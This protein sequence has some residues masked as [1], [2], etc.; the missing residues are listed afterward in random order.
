[1]KAN[2]GR[3]AR[4]RQPGSPWRALAGAALLALA[5]CAAPNARLLDYRAATARAIATSSYQD[6]Y[7]RGNTLAAMD[8]VTVAS[9][10]NEPRIVAQSVG[11]IEENAGAERGA[12]AGAVSLATW[13]GARRYIGETFE[14]AWASVA[15]GAA[16]WQLGQHDNA[17]ALWRNAAQIDGESDEGYREDYG[18]ANFLLAKW[19]STRRNEPDNA[20]IYRDRLLR[21]APQAQPIATDAALAGD[22]VVLLLENGFGPRK[23][24]EGPQG[25]IL[26]YSEVTRE[27][28]FA[29][30]RAN[31]RAVGNDS[32][33]LVDMRLQA[34]KSLRP[35]TKE[36]WQA[37]RG[38][39]VAT[40]VGYGV[41]ELT[42]DPALGVLAALTT[43]A[44]PADQ[45]QWLAVPGEVH[46]ISARLEPGVYDFEIEFFGPGGAPRP[47]LRTTYRG[48]EVGDGWD[49]MLLVRPFAGLGERRLPD[50]A[51]PPTIL[52]DK[53][54]A[55]NPEAPVVLRSGVPD[56]EWTR[57]PLYR[58]LPPA[59]EGGTAR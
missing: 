48:V 46:A 43:K 52:A 23:L 2:K 12:L 24:A 36:V 45:R 59:P 41:Y 13:E 16:Y 57:N 49:A 31:G 9:L 10:A 54:A 17:A 47:E 18:P 3:T 7:A 1:M 15:G 30:L 56:R 33:N 42:D 38:T 40:G 6:P 28:S 11:M 53:K 20:R 25:S 35:L 55:A 39:A 26:E 21:S 32:V 8:A 4:P 14:R 37:I 44:L 34:A 27:W 50:P 22:N 58:Y 51:A 5:G 29:R 19:Y